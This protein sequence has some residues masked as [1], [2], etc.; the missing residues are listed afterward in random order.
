MLLFTM[1]VVVVVVVTVGIVA[2][3]VAVYLYD[4]NKCA[5]LLNLGSHA[6]PNTRTEHL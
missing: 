1:L 2:V 3:V 5:H 6:C 4:N